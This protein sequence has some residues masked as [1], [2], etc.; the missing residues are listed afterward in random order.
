MAKSTIDPDLDSKAVEVS[1]KVIIHA[2]NARTLVKKTLT[3]AKQKDIEGAKKALL[4]ASEEIRSAHVTQTEIIQAEAKG[5]EINVTLLLTHAQ[6]TLMVAKSEVEYTKYIID[7]F[8]RIT[9]LEDQLNMN[10]SK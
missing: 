7:L 1:F 8:E 9:E 6:D 4:E 2:G 10:S 3:K 5:K